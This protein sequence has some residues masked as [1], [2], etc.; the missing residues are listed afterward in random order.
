MENENLPPFLK[1][2]IKRDKYHIWM[3][4]IIFGLIIIISIFDF[5]KLSFPFERTRAKIDFVF[6][7]VFI[8]YGVIRYYFYKKGK[9]Q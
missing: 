3:M 9:L 4:P 7:L 5:N 6:G 8:S 2:I 1:R